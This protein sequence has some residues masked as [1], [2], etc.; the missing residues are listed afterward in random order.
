MDLLVGAAV[1]AVAVVVG[2]GVGVRGGAVVV[3]AAVVVAVRQTGSPGSGALSGPPARN[4][5]GTHAPWPTIP[6]HAHQWLVRVP[7]EY[8]DPSDWHRNAY[9]RGVRGPRGSV[10]PGR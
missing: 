5:T 6:T 4:T 8:L 9:C 1:V 2:V 10:V 3:G 7:A